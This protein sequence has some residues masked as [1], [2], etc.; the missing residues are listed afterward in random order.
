MSTFHVGFVGLSTTGW[1]MTALA[2]ALVK[3]S[4]YRL[5]AVSTTSKDSAEASAA[6]QAEATG[7]RVTPYFGS[8][9]AIANDPQINLVAVAVKSPRHWEALTPVIDA[10]KNFFLEWPAGKN[11]MET[12]KFADA[13]HAKGLRSMVGL[14]GRHTAVIKTVKEILDAGKIGKIL[15]T[16]IIALAPSEL[17]YWGPQVAE[18]N[19][20]TA[21]PN[22]GSSMLEIAIGHHLDILTYLMGD[23]ASVS[24]T[25]ATLFPKADIV[26]ENGSGISKTIDNLLADHIVI[27]GLLKSGAIA[28]LSWR[29]GYAS[30]GRHQLV[31]VIDGEKG[32]IRMSGSSAFIHIR[33]PE[34]Y[35]NEELV[36]VSNG[37]LQANIAEGWEEFTKGKEGRHATIDDAVRI[38]S[39]IDAIESSSELGKKIDL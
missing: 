9:A 11:L 12:K 3:N 14:Q 23:F 36:Q 34:L 37:G 10:G 32:A 16:S 22:Q 19:L 7:Q 18:R 39:L 6:R 29:G 27:N 4:K 2:P 28:S 35:L 1:A 38:R 8:T 30:K 15:S 5:I 24:A 33:D 20:F 25:T 31:W 21:I 26:P 17:Q 13:A